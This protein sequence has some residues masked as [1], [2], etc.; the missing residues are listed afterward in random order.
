M[1]S[2]SAF[3]NLERRRAKVLLAAKVASMMGRKLEEGDWS[4]VYCRSKE[5]TRQGL[6]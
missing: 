1:H 5:H 2:L 6:E 3:S 4:E